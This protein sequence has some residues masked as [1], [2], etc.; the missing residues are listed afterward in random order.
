VRWYLLIKYFLLLY[1]IL[2][3]VC[4][5]GLR[6]LT[7]GVVHEKGLLPQDC[8][9]KI[10]YITYFLNLHVLRDYIFYLVVKCCIKI[11]APW[12]TLHM[13]SDVFTVFNL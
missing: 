8:K 10:N 9:W 2:I 13:L 3:K 5:S 4:F 6:P 7:G 12:C 1:F 11:E